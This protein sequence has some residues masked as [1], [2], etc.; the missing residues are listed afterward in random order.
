MI[1][2]IEF[3][4]IAIVWMICC[5]WVF[6]TNRTFFDTL[7]DVAYKIGHHCLNINPM[8]R[9]INKT[10]DKLRHYDGSIQQFVEDYGEDNL[11]KLVQTDNNPI[12]KP[13]NYKRHYH[14]NPLKSKLIAVLNTKS[15]N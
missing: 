3:I 10:F 8:N 4:M 5:H 14:K 9:F 7:A 2:L 6:K 1:S 15:R 11:R 13:D 12:K